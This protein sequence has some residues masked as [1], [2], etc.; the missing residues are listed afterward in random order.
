MRS[1]LVRAVSLCFLFAF[2]NPVAWGAESLDRG[3]VFQTKNGTVVAAP[4][5]GFTVEIRKA[6]MTAQ[7]LMTQ[8]FDNPSKETLDGFYGIPLPEDAVVDSV[9]LTVGGHPVQGVF[10][11]RDEARQTYEAASRRGERAALIERQESGD[12][13][14]S[15]ANLGPGESAQ[16]FLGMRQVVRWEQGRFS[17][18]VP[19][20]ITVDTEIDWDKDLDLGEKWTP[21]GVEPERGMSPRQADEILAAKLDFGPRHPQVTG[22]MSLVVVEEAATDEPKAVEEARSSFHFRTTGTLS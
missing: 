20:R 18:K 7:T 6:G 9:W 15:V 14:T 10:Q 5:L 12:F 1:K 19:W 8:Y 21:E 22:V 3:L 17:L 13:T 11:E 16:V 2:A 4:A